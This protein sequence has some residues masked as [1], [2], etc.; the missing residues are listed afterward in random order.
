MVENYHAM[1]HSVS[2]VNTSVDAILR[3]SLCSDEIV[4]DHL[5]EIVPNR[6]IRLRILDPVPVLLIEVSGSNFLELLDHVVDRPLVVGQRIDA[7]LADLLSGLGEGTFDEVL[8]DLTRVVL[9]ALP[10]SGPERRDG[11]SGVA[12]RG[13]RDEFQLRP[14]DSIGHERPV[15]P[16]AKDVDEFVGRVPVE[17]D[18]LA[19]PEAAR[20]ACVERGHQFLLTVRDE[21]QGELRE[22]VKVVEKVLVLELV[23]LV[24]RDDAGR[25]IVLPQPF[26]KDISR[27]GLAVDVDGALDAVEDPVEDLEAR[28]ILPAVDVLRVEV[29]ALLME[30]VDG[31]LRDTGLPGSGGTSQEGRFGRFAPGDGF[32]HAREVVHL[33][34]AVDHLSGDELRLEVAGVVEHMWLLVGKYFNW[35]RGF[36]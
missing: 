30:F 16:L 5:L 1:L 32:E 12:T 18:V 29:E 9:F 23:H 13:V 7:L 10:G 8:G 24:E 11:D 21:D 26:E 34:V 25:S 36:S 33:G 28:V 15:G 17:P 35:M 31:E 19:P 3:R 27:C 20:E 22:P 2:W 6:T 4:P 14:V